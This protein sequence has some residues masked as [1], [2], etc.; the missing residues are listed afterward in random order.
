MFQ[1]GA[2]LPAASSFFF[3]RVI[4]NPPLPLAFDPLKKEIF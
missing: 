1:S 4:F 2:L 3:K